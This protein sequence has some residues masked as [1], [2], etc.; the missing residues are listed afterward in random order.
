MG[1]FYP[2]TELS[3]FISLWTFSDIPLTLT[4]LLHVSAFNAKTSIFRLDGKSQCPTLLC[5]LLAS[6]SLLSFFFIF[7]GRISSLS[8]TTMILFPV[9]HFQEN[10]QSLWLWIS[11][12]Y[13]CSNMIKYN[14][15]SWWWT[16]RPGMLRFMGSQRVRHDWG[17][18]QNWSK[19]NLPY[20]FSPGPCFHI[21]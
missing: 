2:V 18:E 4:W 5:F 13:W 1:G 20:T 19:Q 3:F 14:S 11:L 12:I 8:S 6:F 7:E 16:G 21:Y 10:T 9:I 15:G 17:T